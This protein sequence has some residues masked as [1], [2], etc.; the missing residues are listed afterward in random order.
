[1]TG[2]EILEMTKHQAAGNDFLVLADPEDR[3][4]LSAEEVRALCER[5]RGLGA[6]GLIRL[7]AGERDGELAMDL[8]NADGTRAE[9]SGNGIRCLVQAAVDAGLSSPGEVK[10]LTAAGTKTVAFEPAKGGLAHATVD[11]GSVRLMGE[12]DVADL[13]GIARAM[14]ADIGNPH[15]VLLRTPDGETPSDPMASFGDDLLG[16]LGPRLSRSEPAGA[17]VELVSVDAATGRLYMRVYERG[18]G[19]TLACG[20]GACASVFSCASW[21][22]V[23]D[24]AEVVTRGG[25]LEVRI[26]GSRAF[27]R[28]PTRRVAT[29]HVVRSDLAELV[30]ERRADQDAS[31]VLSFESQSDAVAAP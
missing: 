31:R 22:V 13:P 16:R 26:E 30:D 7:L 3:F 27:L 23:T 29:V 9:M 5:R 19:E 21:G 28:G 14:E 10:V 2:D 25:V 18:V 24:E 15:L 4:A 6:D 1:M 8:H 20:T 12:R 11:M 17:N